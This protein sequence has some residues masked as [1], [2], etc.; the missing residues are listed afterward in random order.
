[1][2]TR[3]RASL[4]VAVYRQGMVIKEMPQLKELGVYV[5]VDPMQLLALGF[6]VTANI[7]DVLQ[8]EVEA[9]GLTL[10]HILTAIGYNGSVA[11]GAPQVP[12][13]WESLIHQFCTNLQDPATILFDDSRHYWP[14][15][16]EKQGRSQTFPL[17]YAK[18]TATSQLSPDIGSRTSSQP[19]SQL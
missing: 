7:I 10:R 3:N 17:G 9:E 15:S 16:Q 11:E 1:M 13:Q 5:F 12:K 6:E 18:I 14:S 2:V 4:C 8:V 19:A